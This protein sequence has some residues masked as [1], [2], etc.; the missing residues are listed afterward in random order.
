MSHLPLHT[1]NHALSLSHADIRI[2]EEMIRQLAEVE[3][4]QKQFSIQTLMVQDKMA[5]DAGCLLE[6]ASAQASLS[7]DHTVA[8]GHLTELGDIADFGAY[9]QPDER[10]QLKKPGSKQSGSNS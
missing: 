10:V 4:P 5:A 8:N 6:I 7:D 9:R 1:G 2:M 3:S